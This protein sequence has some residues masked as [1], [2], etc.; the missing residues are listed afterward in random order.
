LL[1]AFLCVNL[2]LVKGRYDMY[3]QRR[4]AVSLLVVLTCSSAFTK[5]AAQDLGNNPAT[6]SPSKYLIE[7]RKPDG[8]L[9]APIV[10]RMSSGP[11]QP[12]KITYGENHGSLVYTLP[13]PTR[14]LPDSSGRPIVSQVRFWAQ[15]YGE[16]WKVM[17]IVGTGEFFDAG[18]HKVAD[19]TLRT[20]E[21]AEVGGMTQFGLSPFHVGV[22]KLI[23]EM[24]G[25]PRVSNKTQ[26]LAVESV[27][28]SLLPRPYRLALKNNS[29]KHVLAIQ[30]NTYK[31]H[32]FLSLKWV[33]NP[34]FGP[35]VKAGQVYNLEVATEDQTCGDAE[36]YR[37]SQSNRIEIATVVFA[38]GSYE[39]DSGLAAL[40]R[41]QAHGNREHLERIVAA[42]SNL[43]GDGQPNPVATLSNRGDGVPD[44]VATLSNRG[45]GVPDP[46]VL[47]YHLKYLSETLEEVAPPYLVEVLRNS[48]PPTTDPDF[49]FTL[50]NFIRSG[51]HEIKTSLR[52]DAQQLERMSNRQFEQMTNRQLEP[53]TNGQLERMSNRQS[54][55]TSDRQLDQ[56]TNRQLDRVNNGQLERMGNGQNIE[57]LKA[58]TARVMAKYKAWLTASQAITNQ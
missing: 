13:R 36:G 19:L 20:N 46:A 47:I 49:N 5:L 3:P 4:I 44:P 25:K 31:N 45:D 24:A 32:K 18:Y 8:C 1:I 54:E 28:A 16:L 6:T 23:G 40:I 14:Y 11:H 27:E 48:L 56:M 42:L 7:V 34:P 10:Q 50:A 29:D 2:R 15:Q 57:T 39:G 53:M 21:R 37:P 38:D 9:F 26:S 33:E 58:F 22:V 12:A 52:H 43:S 41:G 30:Y 17:V 51:Q 35:L 55:Q